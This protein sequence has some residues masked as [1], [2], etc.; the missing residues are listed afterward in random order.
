MIKPGCINLYDEN[1]KETSFQDRIYRTDK[2][3]AA[4]TAGFRPFYLEE[5]NGR[6]KSSRRTAG[7]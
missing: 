6:N 2:I 5:K 7:T 3:S 4:I 1:G